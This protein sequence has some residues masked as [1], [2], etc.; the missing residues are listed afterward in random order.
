MTATTERRQQAADDR[1]WQAETLRDPNWRNH[2]RS[3]HVDYPISVPGPTPTVR[4][5]VT[6]EPQPS[7][8]ILATHVLVFRRHSYDAT[9]PPYRYCVRCGQ[10]EWAAERFPCQEWK[11]LLDYQRFLREGSDGTTGTK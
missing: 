9:Q 7:A 2:G 11:W 6:E 8:E 10:R 5:I 1:Q 3:A 4:R